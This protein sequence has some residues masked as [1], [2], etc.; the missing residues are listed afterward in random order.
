M[1]DNF[2]PNFKYQEFGPMFKAEFFNASM[3]ADLVAA[4]GAKYFV[5]TSKHHD[6]FHLWPSKFN[7]GWNSVD[8]GPKRKE[9]I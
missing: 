6:G 5:L 3:W 1:E 7:F 9:Y 8:V 2:A 4:S